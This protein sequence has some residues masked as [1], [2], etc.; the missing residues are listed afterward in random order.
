M[1]TASRKCLWWCRGLIWDQL[2]TLSTECPSST[3]RRNTPIPLSVSKCPTVS[4]APKNLKRLPIVLKL[5]PTTLSKTL[6]ARV[7]LS[8]RPPLATKVNPAQ[9]ITSHQA[10][11]KPWRSSRSWAKTRAK[12]TVKPISERHPIQRRSRHGLATSS[13]SMSTHPSTTETWVWPRQPRFQQSIRT[14]HQPSRYRSPKRIM[15]KSSWPRR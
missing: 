4:K 13:N 15:S 7:W 3:N 10:D 14:R 5:R 8:R 11:R 1:C 6:Q 12:V 9:L 2:V